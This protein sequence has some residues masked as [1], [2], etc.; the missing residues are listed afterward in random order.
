MES[1][2]NARLNGLS[3][4][5]YTLK[6]LDLNGVKLRSLYS[7]AIENLEDSRRRIVFDCVVALKI[8]PLSGSSSARRAILTSRS[9]GLLR[10]K[11]SADLMQVRATGQHIRRRVVFAPILG[12]QEIIIRK[13]LPMSYAYH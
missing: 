12:G 2:D 7:E 3:V 6:P 8:V 13:R 9:S 11:E 10:P 1:G 5:P 4:R